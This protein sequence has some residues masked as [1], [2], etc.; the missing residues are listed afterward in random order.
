MAALEVEL[1]EFDAEGGQDACEKS[2]QTGDTERDD[3][4]MCSLLSGLGR[5]FRSNLNFA[6]ASFILG[7][8]AKN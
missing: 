6:N 2:E 3:E 5:S 8:L 7:Q 4:H 1:A